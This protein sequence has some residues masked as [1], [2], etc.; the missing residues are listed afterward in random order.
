MCRSGN[1]GVGVTP[2]RC[3]CGSNSTARRHRRKAEEA[4]TRNN[5]VTPNKVYVK[6]SAE[7][8]PTWEAVV[9]GQKELNFLFENQPTFENLDEQDKWDSMMEL[10]VTSLGLAVAREAE[11]GIN[12]TRANYWAE[13]EETTPEFDDAL[14]EME[15]AIA[16]LEDLEESG[17]SEDE[18]YKAENKVESAT[19]NF[20]K[21]SQLDDE[22]QAKLDDVT[23]TRLGEAYRSKIA[24]LRTLGG[25]DVVASDASSEKAL[26]TVNTIVNKYYP[27]EWIEDS[28][29]AGGLRAKIVT[30]NI[31]PY[32]SAGVIQKDLNP[33]DYPDFAEEKYSA[34]VTVPVPEEDLENELALLNGL[35][36]VA[37]ARSFPLN[38]KVCRMV[39]MPHQRIFDPSEDEVNDDGTP[40]GEG[41]EF[42]HHIDP[43]THRAS[44]EKKWVKTASK[45][46]VVAMTDLV[47]R[48]EGNGDE[49][50]IE[51]TAVHEF[52]HRMENTVKNG[53]LMRQEEAFLRRRTTDPVTG[54]RE[55]LSL[56]Y[57]HIPG[58]S[59]FHTEV[60]RRNS[61]VDH[62]VGKEYTV[63]HNREVLTV[64]AEAVFTGSMGGLNGVHSDMPEDA[65][66]KG[67]ILGLFASA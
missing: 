64:G 14:M 24:E 20:N 40:A 30:P 33:D 37:D 26:D 32:C 67:F 63:T 41:W 36:K 59:F 56:I 62:Y 10:K 11:A 49:S 8:Y 2:R 51:S 53:L 39:T 35:G 47:V 23:L 52:G 48:V 13:R 57:G 25:V 45:S 1:E 7:M 54:E 43:A 3:N 12:F 61:F 5:A 29:A 27:K 44:K 16:E 66:H 60:G 4:R 31:R 42:S 58:M 18:I 9:E 46:R 15:D 55:D 21:Q 17:A 28:N 50:Q 38:G 34:Y 6:P 22:R 65:D 19:E